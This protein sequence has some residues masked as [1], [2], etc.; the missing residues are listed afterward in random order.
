MNHSIKICIGIFL[1]VALITIGGCT[2]YRSSKNSSDSTKSQTDEMLEV[3]KT[4]SN[5]THQVHA[6]APP[7]INEREDEFSVP[8]ESR[9]I[10]DQNN[11]STRL[12]HLVSAFN[13]NDMSDDEQIELWE[14][15]RNSD[16][17]QN[18][19]NASELNV[20]KKPTD[21][22]AK[23]ELSELYILKLLSLPDSPERG[24]WAGKAETQWT[25][26]LQIDP[27]NWDARKNTALTLSQYPDFLNRQDE[28]INH[29]EKLV[30]V[31]SRMEP[32]EKFQD[33]YLEL[34][35]MYLKKGN[36][37]SAQQTILE[38]LAFFPDNSQLLQQSRALSE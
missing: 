26:V 38:G 15:V 7:I 18:K 3:E 8:E 5:H 27:D 34:T 6:S 1:T 33:T 11:R 16:E 12:D 24:I 4:K 31:Q 22:A 35:R 36:R 21:I 29:Y 17:F 2:L 28:S 23:M 37:I 9:Q 32:E 20:S 10:K 19:V 25:D 14:M 30:E 13:S